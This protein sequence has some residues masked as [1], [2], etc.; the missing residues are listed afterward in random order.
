MKCTAPK[1]FNASVVLLS[2]FSVLWLV[3]PGPA[4]TLNYVFPSGTP[5]QPANHS[6]FQFAD[7]I[8]G[9]YPHAPYPLMIQAAVQN[10]PPPPTGG[11]ITT[12]INWMN[13]NVNG[14]DHAA[15]TIDQ[16][17]RNG[18][19]G[20]D[21]SSCPNPTE[22]DLTAKAS[23]TFTTY[24]PGV[25]PNPGTTTTT[26]QV[27][28]TTGLPYEMIVGD[29]AM[30]GLKFVGTTGAIYDSQP[31]VYEPNATHPYHCG[32]LSVNNAYTYPAAYVKGTTP[33]V[34]M[35]LEDVD[36]A[37]QSHPFVSGGANNPAVRVNWWMTF[38]KFDTTTEPGYPVSDVQTLTAASSNI[39]PATP[40]VLPAL[41]N[42]VDS[43]VSSQSYSFQVHYSDGLGGQNND[44]WVTAPAS[45]GAISSDS[46]PVYVTLAAPA[47][48]MST[49]YLGVLQDACSWAAGMSTA[50]A[51][52]TALTGNLYNT[53]YYDP[54]HPW[55]TTGTPPNETFYVGDF[56]YGSVPYGFAQRTGQCNDIADYLVCL[57]N[58]IGARP[59]K[60]QNQPG[61]FTCNPLSKAPTTGVNAAP[62]FNYHQ[63][64]NDT[65]IFDACVKWGGLTYPV[66]EP[67]PAGPANPADT[68]TP[69]SAYFTGTVY[70]GL[71]VQDPWI[72][73]PGTPFTPTIA[74]HRP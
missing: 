35:D 26:T 12:F 4:Q 48:P 13:L 33:T 30:K 23:V 45:G 62:Y 59:L 15:S 14:Q 64:T 2:V 58:A 22:F 61:G 57:S 36:A 49:P 40:A 63:F 71:P 68:T 31:D 27:L 34:T 25:Y 72:W 37:G 8:T 74:N 5:G 46:M 11:S 73:T 29:I 16:P 65:T 19:Y 60:S 66:D 9:S 47:A 56:R 69:A 6:L 55:D 50:T 38:R 41:S 43:L 52:T 3:A 18:A 21:I 53:S 44:G 1:V 39:A 32:R 24:T 17:N 54:S 67:G 20:V 42:V 70:I 7:P 10:V 51:A 28:S